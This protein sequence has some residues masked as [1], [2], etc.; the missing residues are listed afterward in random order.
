MNKL[1]KAAFVL[2]L[3]VLQS[4]FAS[5]Q[6]TI[7]N[8]ESQIKKGLYQE[9]LLTL[10]KIISQNPTETQA[11][12]LLADVQIKLG[13]IELATATY[14]A[15]ENLGKTDDQFYY[16]YGL[17]LK[18]QGKYDQAI[19]KFNKCTG[20]NKELA[21]KQ[22][23]S[24]VFAK[25][26]IKSDETK[27]VMNMDFNTEYNDFGATII[28]NTIVYNSNKTPYMTEQ[29]KALVI[30]HNSSFVCKTLMNGTASALF[31]EGKI[32]NTNMEAIAIT[33]NSMVTYSVV[34]NA[35]IDLSDRMKNSAVFIGKYNG[36]AIE[37]VLP[38]EFNEEGISNYSSCISNDGNT[39]YFA[40][41]RPG[42]Y[43]GFDIYKSNFDGKSW[44][45]PIN[46]GD[47]INTTGNEITP[48]YNESLLYFASD[49]HNGL[50]G[51]D[52]F[53]AQNLGDDFINVQ[54]MGIGINSS[55]N[56]YYPSIK[57]LVIYFSSDRE[58]GKGMCDVYRAPLSERHFTVEL[59]E[60][61]TVP[62]P[63][64]L[65]AVEE[66]PPPA[67]SLNE[68]MYGSRSLDDID[69]LLSGARRVSFSEVVTKD[70]PKVFFIQ[71]ASMSTDSKGSADKFKALIKF[72]NIY[73]VKVNNSTKVRLGYFLERNETDV[74]LSKVRG[75]G[76]KD[77]FIVEQ[78][79]ATADL[80]LMLS[81]SDAYPDRKPAPST[82]TQPSTNVKTPKTNTTK[83]DHNFEYTK[84]IEPS[85]DRE[86]KVR[87]GSFEDP[88][89]FDSKKVKD[90]GKVEQWTKGAW[91]IFILSGYK[92]YSAADQARIQAINRGYTDAEVVV[93]NGG[94][95]ERLKKN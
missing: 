15:I 74:L 30:D 35:S 75:S 81:Q 95:I 84:P 87:L 62:A 91:T 83:E 40:S 16:S 4:S 11:F 69:A 71:L 63:M 54:N 64:A 41:D 51:Y 38:F 36:F 88:I 13:K 2:S 43:G 26:L 73:K 9:S 8:A 49:A 57:N 24:C 93:D 32:N 18:M 28:S 72:G 70:K 79:L 23:Q 34:N 44:S 82:N 58:N 85:S 61:N 65:A 90:L 19:A 50:G 89:W 42:G 3:L 27:K 78:E 39:L 12:M 21:G 1:L 94:I 86:Y 25:E 76:F 31:V 14:S 33:D 77:A 7:A 66:T 17:A 47:D 20:Q 48:F 45:T 22:I 68:K 55:S 37:N 60:G 80:E 59:E 56:D 46:L 67:Y 92:D 52:I 5:G 53:T 10:N 29:S 6:Y